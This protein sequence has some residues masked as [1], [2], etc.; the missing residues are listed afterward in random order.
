MTAD[1]HPD[2]DSISGICEALMEQITEEDTG[3]A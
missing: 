2:R 1:G 3:I